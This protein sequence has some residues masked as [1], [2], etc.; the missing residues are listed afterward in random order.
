MNTFTRRQW[1]YSAAVAS[2]AVSAIG[3]RPAIADSPKSDL[4]IAATR[5][6]ITSRS[7]RLKNSRETRTVVTAIASDPRGELLAAAGDDHVIRILQASTLKTLHTLTG[8]RDLIRTLSFDREGDRLVSAGNDGQ[9]ILWDREESFSVQ[10]RWSGTPALACVCFH[11]QGFELAAVG[12]HNKIYIVGR[13][14]AHRATFDC[15]C[16]DLR[17]VA[18]RDDMQVLAVA[19]RNGA[20]HLFDPVIGESFSEI[21]LH[22]GRIHDIA[23]QPNSSRVICVG[24]DGKTTV[25]DTERGKLIHRVHVTTS[26]LFAVTILNNELV[27]V[28]G[29][30]NVIRIIN[31][32]SGSVVR[33]LKGHNGSVSTLDSAG[34]WL[35]SGS[36][37]ATLRRW[38]VADISTSEQRIAEGDPRIDR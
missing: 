20:L 1:L 38:A 36:Y 25:F 37:D 14:E 2:L 19:G 8:H 26:K 17:A 6:P 28:A 16:R 18:Y 23:F 33:T 29:S 24:E 11:P 21:P 35:F 31:I 34:G 10:K 32:D 22:V 9:M 7:I 5:L 3:G 30:D 13:S 15:D 4:R 27:A 12:F